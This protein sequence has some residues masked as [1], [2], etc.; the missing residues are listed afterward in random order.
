MRE[1]HEETS[2]PTHLSSSSFS[3]SSVVLFLLLLLIVL[4]SSIFF[5]IICLLLLLHLLPLFYPV[6]VASISLRT[7]STFRHNQTTLLL[8]HGEP[9]TTQ[10]SSG[11]PLQTP[12][13]PLSCLMLRLPSNLQSATRLTPRWRPTHR[14]NHQGMSRTLRSRNKPQRP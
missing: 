9:I 5:F 13:P 10:K 4:L 6:S 7:R 11:P 8:T 14:S 12:P 1:L 2:P 3:S